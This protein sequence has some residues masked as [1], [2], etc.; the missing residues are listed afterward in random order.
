MKV[1]YESYIALFPS[2]FRFKP[3]SLWGG[4][5]ILVTRESCLNVKYVRNRHIIIRSDLFVSLGLV[6]R[7]IHLI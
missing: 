2:Y 7:L 4:K 3:F 1:T 5:V 6:L